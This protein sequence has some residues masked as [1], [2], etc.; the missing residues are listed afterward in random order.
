MLQLFP[1]PYI[2]QT[3]IE[4]HS[5]L[6]QE[7]LPKILEE[8]NQNQFKDEYLWTPDSNSGVKTN[9]SHMDPTLLTIDQY[10]EI[11]WNP[12]DELLGN[13]YAEDS[14]IKPSI[15]PPTN[16]TISGLWWNVYT[17]GDY[18]ELHNH[19]PAGI[20]GIYF[21]DLP[22]DTKNTTVF[23]HDNNYA[24]SHEVQ[25]WSQK[26]IADYVK[27]GDLLLFPSSMHHYVDKSNGKKVSIS[28]NVDVHF[29]GNP[30]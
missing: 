26:H 21:I 23:V 4:N 3:Q 7:I 1:G 25:L 8:Y 28:F 2:F 10:K 5:T 20:S 27:E 6:K 9:Y 16:S 11:V 14:P 17:P 18:V 19:C 24:L 15:N 29:K 30:D 12:V 13:L 22:E